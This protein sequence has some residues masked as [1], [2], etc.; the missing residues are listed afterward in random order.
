MSS[1]RSLNGQIVPFKI[2]VQSN[3]NR[4]CISL[5]I[6]QRPQFTWRSGAAKQGTMGDYSRIAPNE[7]ASSTSC[8]VI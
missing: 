8:Q 2:K 1:F 7:Q 5:Q 6:L 4:A 3:I